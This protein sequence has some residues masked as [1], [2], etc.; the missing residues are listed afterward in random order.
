MADWYADCYSSNGKSIDWGGYG[1]GYSYMY[2][3]VQRTVAG[4]EEVYY[5]RDVNS[6]ADVNKKYGANSGVIHLKDGT[7]VGN[8]QYTVYNDHA[9]NING[10]VK[11]VNGNVVNN[12]KTVLYGDNYTLFA[13]I[14]EKSL[15]P[16]TLHTNWLDNSSYIGPKN[17]KNYNGEYNYDYQP[18]WSSTEMAARQH[19]MDYD[20]RGAKGIWGA[21]SPRTKCADLRLINTCNQIINNPNTSAFEKNRASKMKTVF[22]SLNFIFKTPHW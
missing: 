5:D 6:Q 3:W 10:V 20:A 7:R 11:D 9:N 16:A 8:G 4:R 2:D 14:T 15:D 19:D 12:D 1:S 18:A 13:G 22:G 17:P 21:I